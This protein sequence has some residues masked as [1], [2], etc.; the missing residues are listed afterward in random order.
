[1][2]LGFAIIPLLH[3]VS[4]KRRM[5]QFA[6]GFWAKLGGWTSALVIVA[7]NIWLVGEKVLEW[8]ADGQWAVQFLVVPVLLFS[9]G[10]LCYI[11]LKPLLVKH[12][13]HEK[14]Y[15]P[16]GSFKGMEAIQAP[17][18]HKIAIALDFSN[19]DSKTMEHALHI[20][21][22]NAQYFL[23]HAVETAGAW[24]MGSDIQDLETNADVAN[25]EQYA[26]AIRELG[27]PCEACIGYGSAKKAI[28]QL[29]HEKGAD[30]LVMGSHGHKAMKDLIFGTTVGAV[31]H[32][33]AIP[34]LIVR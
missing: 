9:L 19:A 2:Q 28:P 15:L 4:D 20:G 27:F 5:G 10:M 22:K 6:I 29:V 17:D 23:I 16:H 12:L 26:N 32:A 25:L 7:L 31:R 21:G 8:M 14:T 33:V 11:T 1:M 34:V 24:V 30:L 3:Y 18:Y 13:P